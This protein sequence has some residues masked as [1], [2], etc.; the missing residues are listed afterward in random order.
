MTNTVSTV[1]RPRRKRFD[2]MQTPM[3]PNR[4]KVEIC[5]DHEAM[6]AAAARR[7][8]REFGRDRRLLVC[9]AT[10]STPARAY[11]LLG[12]R[13]RKSPALFDHLRVLKLDEWAGLPAG[14]PGSSEAYLRRRV[15]RPWGVSPR[16]FVGFAT[17]SSRPRLECERIQNWLARNGPIDVCVLGLG[18]NGHL[19]FN[20]PGDALRPIAHRA[21]LSEQTRAHPMVS[22]TVVKPKYG[23]TLGMAE[24]FQARQILLLVSGAHK[25]KALNRLF[26]GEIS[27]QFPASFLSLHPQTTVFCDCAAAAQIK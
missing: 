14:D 16:R 1:E 4:M 24:I 12:A 10:G 15:V 7:I 21:L 22:H 6:S 2:L 18:S 26:R 25:R 9:L 27:T 23:L 19:G 5:T 20:E 17:D 3:E 13:A 8:A 11:E